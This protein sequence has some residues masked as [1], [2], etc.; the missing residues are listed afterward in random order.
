M[1]FKMNIR[2]KARD[3]DPIQHFREWMAEA[4]AGEPF[5]PNAMALATAGADGRPSVRMVL[6]K[7]VDERG[8]V[9]YTNSESPK[10]ADLHANARASLCFY[11]KSLRREVRV[12]GAVSKV[13]GEEADAYFASRA[14][15]SQIGAWASAQSRP[16]A[17]R[18]ELEKRI[19]R[20][21]AKFHIG[22]VPRPPHWEGY[23]V[24]PQRL[25]FWAEGRFRLH[26][27]IVYTRTES[28]WNACH[29]F[30]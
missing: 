9:F 22:K 5:N 16:M 19:A 17:G 29:L 24:S 6:L 2:L 25:E 13:A 23:R 26:D 1:R 15:A 8:F 7:G 4:E 11:W 3:A 21:T 14:R 18:F 30:P 28:G 12:D 20:F 10:G 27:R